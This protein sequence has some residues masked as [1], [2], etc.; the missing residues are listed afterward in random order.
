MMDLLT[1]D[2]GL[3]IFAAL[4]IAMTTVSIVRDARVQKARLLTVIEEAPVDLD[5]S[6][7]A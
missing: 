7:A 5:L 3:A 1:G 4:G 2:A 6:R